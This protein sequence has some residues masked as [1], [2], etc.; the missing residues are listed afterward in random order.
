[1]KRW[2]TGAFLFCMVG[3]VGFAAAES[4]FVGTWKL[5]QAKS[6]MT[7]STMKF[8]SAGSGMIRETVA[9]GSYTIKTNGEES[10]G[11]FGDME[12]WKTLSGHSWQSTVREH[13]GYTYTDMFVVSDDGS[14]LTVTSEGKNPNGSSF[15]DEVV[16]TRIAGGKGLMGTWKS[17]SVK[18]SNP[19]TLEFVA[20]GEN[21]LIWKLPQMKASV[22][23]EFNGKD[24]AP[25]GPTIPSGL[26]LSFTKISNRSFHMTEKMNGKPI[27]RGRYTVSAGGKTLTETGMPVGQAQP[28]R[29]VYEK[30]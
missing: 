2:I 12:S 13:G 3:A 28:D 19:G 7:G 20:N 11:L 21:G 9:E 4:P 18:A 29:S 8:S 15:H 23:V 24:I 22:N 6:H 5:N 25:E 1:M 10:P 17:T 26:T 16:Y 14:K 30:E 27:Y